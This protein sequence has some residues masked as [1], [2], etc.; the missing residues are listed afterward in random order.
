L[1]EI[2]TDLS[3]APYYDDYDPDKQYYRILG[4]PRRAVQ[5]REWNQLQTMSQEQVKRHA[6]HQFKDGSIVDGCNITYEPNYHFVHVATFVNDNANTVFSTDELKEFLVVS[7]TTGLRASVQ[8][9][10]PGFIATYPNTNILYVQYINKGRDT[11]DN[12]ITEFSASETLTLYNKTQDKLG[13]LNPGNIYNQ[14]LAYTPLSGQ[15]ATGTAYAVSVGDGV[16]YQKGFF[17]NVQPNTVLVN[18]FSQDVSDY[19]VGFET[20]EQIV[21]YLQDRSLVDP[22]DTSS[23]NGIGA[24][25]LKLTPVLVAKKRADI[26]SSDDFFPIIEFGESREPVRQNSDPAYAALG[27][28]LS[29]TQYETHGDFYIKPFMIGT[30]GVANTENFAYTVD[31]GIAY[32]K[33]NRVQLLNT[34]NLEQS[35]ATAIGSYNGNITTLNYGNYVVIN[36]MLGTFNADKI[37]TVNIYDTAQ[38]AVVSTRSPQTPIGNLVGTANVRAVQYLSGPKSGLDT[39][40][41]MYI[42]NINMT[43][44]KSFVNDAK[45]FVI[46]AANNGLAFGAIADIVL[47]D[48]KAQLRDTG[49]SGLIFN[50]GIVGTRRL[51]DAGGV[52]D[53]SF[54]YRDTSSATL[55]ANGSVTFTLNTPHAGGAER[56]FTSVGPLSGVNKLRVDVTTTGA[57]VGANLA[58]TVNGN[59]GNTSI[60]GVGTSFINDFTIGEVIR[61]AN[62]NYRVGSIANN[63]FMTV[64]QNVTGG[65]ANNTYAKSYAAGS[66]LDLTTSTVTAISNTQFSIDLGY[67]VS[68][69]APQTLVA[70]YP[71]IRNQAYEIKKD[72]RK[73]TLI[74]IDCANNVAGTNGPFDLGLVD[75]YNITNVWVGST[76]S[77]NNPDRKGWFVLDGG[78]QPSHYDHAKLILRP[79]H[80][81]KLDASTK[82]LVQV[83]HFT[84]NTATGIGFFSVDSYPVRV[85]GAVANTTNISYDDIPEVFGYNLR[86]A[87]DFRPQKFNT[88]TIT[89]SAGSATINPAASNTSFNISTSGSY[90]GEPDSNFQADAENYLPRIDVIQ[91]NKDGVFS[92]KS[93]NPAEKP[94]APIVDQDAM[95]VATSYVS[96]YPG[97]TADMVGR[98]PINKPKIRTSLTGHRGYTMRDIGS[99][100][101]RITTLEYYQALSMLEQQAKD[102]VVKDE[103]GLDRFKNGIFADPLK[104]HLLGDVSN[105]EYNIAIDERNQLARPKIEKNNVDLDVVDSTNVKFNGRVASLDYDRKLYIEQKYASKFRNVTESVWKWSGNVAL[106]PEYDHYKNEQALPAVNVEI[107]LATPWEEFAN[108]PFAQDFGDWRVTENTRTATSSRSGNAITTTTTR[109]TTSERVVEQLSI[110][111][112]QTKNDLGSYVT[113]VTLNPYMRSRQIAFVA[114]GLRP[115][116]RYWSYFA[117][118]PVSQHCA[119]GTLNTAMFDQS[120]N[121]LVITSGKED[122]VVTRAGA[123]GT[124]LVSD[125]AGNVYGLFVIPDQQFRVGDRVFTLADVDSLATGKD[126]ILSSAS[127]TYTASALTMNTKN[128]SI[129]TITPSVSVDTRTES[130]VETSTSITRRVITPPAPQRSSSGAGDPLGQTIYADA[131]ERVPGVFLEAYEVFFRTKDPTLGITCYVTEVQAGVPNTSRIVATAYLKPSAI[132]TST[133]SS[134]GTVFKFNEIPY[135]TKDNYY[136]V[137]FA[138]DGNSPEYTIWMS[139]IGGV[140]ILTGEKIFSNPYIGVALRS[141]NSNTWDPL[142]TEDIKFNAYICDFK[143][144]TGEIEFAE[145][146]DDLF[147]V[148]GFALANTNT[149]IQVGDVVYSLN[150]NNTVITGSGAPFG[151]VQEYDQVDDWLLIDSSTG[152]FTANTKIHI[153]RPSQPG[154]PASISNTNLIATTTI[155]SVDDIEYSIVVPRIATQTPTGTNVDYSFRGRDLSGNMD[156]SYIPVQA[157]TELELIDKMRVIRSKSNRTNPTDKSANIKI[158][159][160]TNSSYISPIVDLRRR[161][162]Y[163]IDNIVNNDLTNEHTRYGSAL[164]K[165]ISRTI[166]LAEGQDAED[167]RLRV[168]AYRPTNT[169]VSVYV[170]ILCGDDSDNFVDKLWTKLDMV[171]GASAFSSSANVDDFREYV[172]TFP[173]TEGIQGTAYRN[174]NN[175]GIVQYRNASGTLFVSYK[176]WAV[177]VVLTASGKQLVPR[178]GDIW[179]I[180]L[181]I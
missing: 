98:Y 8:M 93:S 80:A 119:P 120:T 14:I 82:I 57:M 51:R 130:R 139:E 121:E 108:S 1:A 37:S 178:L 44:G 17:L 162:M 141:S 104:N 177:K 181:Q 152:G 129:T 48:S 126:A 74:K 10:N 50:S 112:Y 21:T 101:R 170:K 27:D 90:L 171:E 92:V 35:R 96:P 69:G 138:P 75:V 134:A 46:N 137:F 2:I 110:E 146:D 39:Q 111:T 172:Y 153:Y 45:S 61:V 30:K 26:S 15:A 34:I 24:D 20:K 7:N 169:D 179:G 32:V 105:F 133:D 173:T 124:P 95:I 67:A 163:A 4:V 3:A 11:S 144:S 43:S 125:S 168:T 70:T 91:V 99:L 113:D 150:S 147:T 114:T 127:V 156:G 180:N 176:Q 25:R 42:S 54:I 164:V 148:E 107:D 76:Y 53:T 60:I 22:A 18:P 154:N 85:P 40:Y 128:I 59:S 64:N 155:N 49:M 38:T 63:T 122:Q 81:G 167:I 166:T 89:T 36:Q 158:A 87:I 142:L 132:N 66:I 115:N 62:T 6:D 157:E 28:A 159:L 140:D 5:I 65:A 83:D 109:S 118:E 31:A 88:A 161:S 135:L 174:V 102:Y 165:Y 160:N 55:Q 100:D 68:T 131:P 47:V 23:R 12:E 97:V 77:T 19:L 145:Q 175:D 136:A 79:E 86:N 143:S 149:S 117:D 29:K 151:I 73:D 41:K 9:A 33:G 106:F 94:V 123:F 84:A 52:N 71:V 78:Q 13:T 58:G 116:T 103:N 16:V 72:V 56:F